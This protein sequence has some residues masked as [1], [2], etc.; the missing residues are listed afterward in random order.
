M[1]KLVSW[2]KPN[3][4]V[5]TRLPDV[6]VHV[7]FFSSPEA[8]V[9]EKM[10]LVQALRPD[11]VLIYNHDDQIIQN[12]LESVRH[13]AIG[14]SRYLKSHFNASAD[15]IIYNDDFPT[16]VSFTLEHLGEEHE[17][18]VLGSIGV[19]FV[20]TYAGA[21][22]VAAQCNISVSDAVLDLESN[23]PAPG[24]MRII[25]GIKGT[26]IIDDT[27]NSSPVAVEQALST[28]KEI[29]HA[30]RKIVVFGDMMELGHFSA[31]EHERVGELAAGTVDTIF[32]IG[33]RSIRTAQ[34]A[35]SGGIKES[36]VFQY[37]DVAKAGKEL[38]AYIMP[39][40]VILVK[41]SQSMRTEKVVEEIMAEPENAPNLL[42]RQDTAW[43]NR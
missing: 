17:V 11:G 40:D 35:L 20:Y 5:L 1:K 41:G 10:N 26:T 30:K 9:E 31:R 33:V 7:E 4:V 16:G 42:V 6:P 37:E 3:I 21:I 28:L 32:A 27:Y 8:V 14:Y 22:A 29:K 38:Q 36:A 34:S 15:K 12:Q 25:K 43:E 2:I 13:K 39:G 23:M 19:P 24:R 18:R